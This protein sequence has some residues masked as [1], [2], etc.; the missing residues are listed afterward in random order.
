LQEGHELYF[1]HDLAT[2]MA[3]LRHPDTNIDLVVGNV[4]E[5]IDVFELI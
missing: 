5:E 3:V 4:Y 2:A 1:A